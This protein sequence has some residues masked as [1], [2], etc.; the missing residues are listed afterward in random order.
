MCGIGILRVPI[1][2]AADFGANVGVSAY[3]LIV[4]AFVHLIFYI[5]QLFFIKSIFYYE[6]ISSMFFEN[7]LSLAR[8]KNCQIIYPCLPC[9]PIKCAPN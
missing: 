7:T 4:N 9:G 2:L 6:R 1:L 8:V 5:S 3:I